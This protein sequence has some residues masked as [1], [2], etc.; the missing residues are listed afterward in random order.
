MAKSILAKYAALRAKAKGEETGK[1]PVSAPK[2]APV[3]DEREKASFF[4]FKPIQ[5]Q[6]PSDEKAAEPEAEKEEENN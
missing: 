4:S 1:A 5:S 3:A 6:I 2:T